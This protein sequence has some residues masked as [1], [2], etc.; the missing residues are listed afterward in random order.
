MEDVILAESLIYYAAY[1]PESGKYKAQRE[2]AHNKTYDMSK[3]TL[4]KSKQTAEK[5]GKRA[6][7]PVAVK[8]K[9]VR[10]Q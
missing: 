1:D 8:I 6:G 2:Y 7:C 3:I 9:L 10:I 4:Y 5:Y